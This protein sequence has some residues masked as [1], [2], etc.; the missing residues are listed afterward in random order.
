MTQFH[1]PRSYGPF[2]SLQQA[3]KASVL[4]SGRSSGPERGAFIQ[5][6]LEAARCAVGDYDRTIARWLA[7]WEPETVGVVM[8]WVARAFE[9]GVNSGAQVFQLTAHL[10]RVPSDEEVDALHAAGLADSSIDYRATSVEMD[11]DRVAYT[12]EEA[13][14]TIVEQVA[15]VPGLSV[16]E[17]VDTPDD[18]AEAPVISWVLYRPQS[19]SEILEPAGVDG[20]VSPALDAGELA[21]EKLVEY[22]TGAWD[23][24]VK[25]YG[26]R[27]QLAAWAQ[28]E[29]GEAVS[30]RNGDAR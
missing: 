30:Y 16:V 11:V 14:A 18:D 13:A 3:I 2:H 19:G 24:V 8:D 29:Q 15:T 12:R 10:N 25:V 23:W 9:A 6:R 4:V 17:I 1:V 20:D 28:W 21:V 22:A 26:A 7:M 5:G 27:G